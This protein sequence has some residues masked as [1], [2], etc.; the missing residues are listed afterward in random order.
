VTRH[1]SNLTFAHRSNIG[2][3]PL[4]S[5]VVPCFNEEAVLQQTNC[6][7]KQVLEQLPVDFE[8]IYVDDG[9]DDSTLEL[10]R[11]FQADDVR[12]RVIQLS[13]NFG[14]QV[15]IT[16]GLEHTLG[17]SVVLID[18]DMQDPPE[19]IPEMISR[20]TS[21][22]D[23]AY[24]IRTERVGETSFKLWT[25]KAF[26]KL[27]DSL[28]D[29]KIPTEAGD[30]RLMDRRVVNAILEMREGD[31]FLRG[32][33]SWAGFKQVAVPYQRASRLAGNSK[34]PLKKMV[35]LA[36]DGIL[37]FSVL[38]L[39]VAT[40]VGFSASM[41]AVIGAAISLFFRLF[42]NRWVTGWTSLLLAIL[43]MGGAQ[44][45]CL[46]IIGEYVGRT[47]GESKHRPLYF[48]Q[49]KLGFEEQKLTARQRA[50][51]A[52]QAWLAHG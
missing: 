15:A 8:I 21:G 36:T 50:G 12:V 26:Y 7:L 19:V 32:M 11:Q 37:S 16:A 35:H 9:S 4:V 30:F 47:Y 1:C 18:A 3:T 28:A 17:D 24:G 22:W 27:I 34:Y 38:P 20:W 42:T 5:V 33:V 31:R 43:F 10:L 48:V 25:A 51:D 6:R 23:V 2:T 52:R 46:G 44:L 41:L 39:K 40:L 45:V 14:H 29:I 49:Q 13:R